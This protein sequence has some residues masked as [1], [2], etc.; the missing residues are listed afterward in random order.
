MILDT[1]AKIVEVILGEG[2]ATSDCEFT[3]DWSDTAAGATF[4]PG[5]AIGLTNGTTVVTAVAAPAASI[6]RH[7]KFLS[8]FNADTVTH[9]IIVR[10]Y[11]GTS[12]RRIVNFSVAAGATLEYSSENGFAISNNSGTVTSVALTAPAEINVVGSP[13]TSAGT[14]A[15]TWANQNANTCLSGPASGSAGTP[16][17]RALVAADIPSLSATYLP[18]IGGTMMGTIT[19]S[20]SSAALVLSPTL[21]G[22]TIAN[23]LIQITL[24]NTNPGGS[25]RGM[26]FSVSNAYTSGPTS[27]FQIGCQATNTIL[28]TNTQNWT[29]ATGQIGYAANLNIV[30]GATGTITQQQV[31]RCAAWGNGA[32]GATLVNASGFFLVAPTTVGPVSNYAYINIGGTSNFTGNYGVLDTSA[33]NWQMSGALRTG[34]YT[35]ATLPSAP[36]DGYRAYVTDALTPAFLGAVVGGG[37]VHTPVY[38]N[39]GTSAWTVG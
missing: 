12:R 25:G 21:T 33:Q 3:A 24:S 10:I 6:Q 2:K 36:G 29:A 37:A 1:A 14:L 32:T 13:I 39:S 16:S 34:I 23:G 8:V 26:Q 31:F 18:L 35:V 17:F 15:L 11:D 7:V 20:T 22:A 4:V 38:Y 5:N 28:A 30:G 19:N 27:N 9:A